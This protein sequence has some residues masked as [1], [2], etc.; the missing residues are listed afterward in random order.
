MSAEDW[1][2]HRDVLAGYLSPYEDVPG[3]DPNDPKAIADWNDD[4][5]FG[6]VLKRMNARMVP[7]DVPLN[8]NA[9]SLVTSAYMY[10][11]DEKYRRWVLDYVEAWAERAKRNGGV[12]PDNV[13]PN[14][15]IGERMD[16]KWWGG[17]L[18]L[19]HI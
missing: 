10:T 15:E 7:G 6:E 16:G 3:L 4:E 13:G 1:V 19:I 2:T 17:Y 9:T 14:D 11:G 12:I 18:S 8:L 5:A